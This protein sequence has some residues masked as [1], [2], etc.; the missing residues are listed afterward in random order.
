[1]ELA[2]EAEIAVAR[3]GV[4]LVGDQR[5]ATEKAAQDSWGQRL[6]A[7]ERIEFR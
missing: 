3:D 5:E 7:G 2:R 1:M 6:V 4:F